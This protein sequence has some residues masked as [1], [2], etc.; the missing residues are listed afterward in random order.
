MTNKCLR[1]STGHVTQA[2]RLFLPAV[3]YVLS[4]SCSLSYLFLRLTSGSDIHFE[5]NGSVATNRYFST[6]RNLDF[7]HRWTGVLLGRVSCDLFQRG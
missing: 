6:I 5:S 1:V 3:A 7:C 4:L 2:E